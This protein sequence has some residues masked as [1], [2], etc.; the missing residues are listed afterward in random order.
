M[1]AKLLLPKGHGHPLWIPEPDENLPSEYRERGLSIGDVGIITPGGGF[2]VLF[3]ACQPATHPIN[4]DSV[5][6]GFVPFM[7]GDGDIVKEPSKHSPGTVITSSD[8]EDGIGC[9]TSQRIKDMWAY[10]FCHLCI[11]RIGLLWG[12]MRWYKVHSSPHFAEPCFRVLMS[13]CQ[14]LFARSGPQSA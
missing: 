10:D 9:H 2:D 3:N 14:G 6:E 1:Y 8:A 13:F 4:N 11:S 12:V 7:L 5:P